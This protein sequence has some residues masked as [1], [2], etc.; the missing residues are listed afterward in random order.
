M[1]YLILH[2][3]GLTGFPHVG[4]DPRTSLQRAT[5]PHLDRLAASGDLGQV[6]LP[7]DGFPFSSELL[8]MALLGYSPK[9]WYPGPSP[10]EAAGLGVSVGE[11]D[12]VYRATMVTLLGGGPSSP[13]P[14]K[15][16]GKRT[17]N[18]TDADIK[19][20]GPH[21]LL[22]D[23]S[24]GGITTEEAREL[25]DAVNEQLGSEAIQLYPG[26]EH[27]H[28]LVWVGGKVRMICR[29]PREALGQ[30]I[31]GFLP[32]GDGSN[33][34]RKLM[35][36]SFVIM[37]DH[38]VNDQRREAG[39]KP[40]NCLWLWGPGR[41]TQWPHVLERYH[42]GGAILATRDVNRGVGVCAG[43][44]AVDPGGGSGSGTSA[45]EPIA[46]AAFQELGRKDLVYLFVESAIGSDGQKDGADRRRWIEELDRRVVGR[47]LKALPKYGPH[48]LLLIGDGGSSACPPTG[49]FPPAPVVLY[50]GVGT[51]RSGTGRRFTETDAAASCAIPWD[52]TKL[53]PRLLARP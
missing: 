30:A 11:Q 23:E 20:F 13:D 43:L 41:P 38:P 16:T 49:P 35:D 27:R 32:T 18:V 51:G 24:A 53:L 4:S 2:V 10:L 29:N 6:A 36:A 44:E 9:K 50:D 15:G 46:D 21:L 48:R 19:K 1:K 17:T 25:I 52:P 28:L 8:Q 31:G 34:L 42:L 37:R 12:V 47:L 33:L 40:A 3:G 14:A 26:P 45:L 22:D 39:L 5:T 7:S